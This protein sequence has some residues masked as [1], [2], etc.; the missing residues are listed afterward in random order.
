MDIYNIKFYPENIIFI[1]VPNGSKEADHVAR[2]LIQSER[3]FKK[4][5]Q[6]QEN[7]GEVKIFNLNKTLFNKLTK[8]ICNLRTWQIQIKMFKPKISTF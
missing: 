7:I 6:K 2:T 4:N 3:G 5:E 1:L 8:P